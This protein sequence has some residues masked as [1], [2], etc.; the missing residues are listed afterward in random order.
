MTHPL[1]FLAVGMATSAGI[2]IATDTRSETLTLPR[3]MQFGSTVTLQPT[4]APGAVAEVVFRN[5]MVN[6]DK[7]DGDY[8]LT[9]GALTIS[10][11]FVWDAN[12]S[13]ADQIT[14]TVPPGYAADPETLTVPEG[15]V[16][17]IIIYDMEAWGY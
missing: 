1:A 10:V 4:E 2:L 17:T 16:G 11:S 12:G 6:S 15:A 7:D 8:P 14:V 3:H 5:A 9:M 13:G